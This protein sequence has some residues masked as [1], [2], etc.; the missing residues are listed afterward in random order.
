MGGFT[1]VELVVVMVLLAVVAS[2]GLGRMA[3]REPFAAQALRDQLTSGLR[4]AQAAAQAQRRTVHVALAANPPVLT[5]CLDA[6][7]TQP[8]KTPAGDVQWLSETAGLRL[9][10]AASFRYAPD[11]ST[12]LGANLVLQV[13]GETGVATPQTLTVE[14]GSGYVH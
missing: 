7:C 10:A 11:G 3:D 8:L 1:L 6:G 4:V 9:S 14:A 13:L 2:I 5:V 12:D